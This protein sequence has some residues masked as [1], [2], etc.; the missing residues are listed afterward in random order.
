MLMPDGD[1]KNIAL[2]PIE[3]LNVDERPALA[4]EDGINTGA[5]MTMRSCFFPRGQELHSAIQGRQS[6]TAGFAVLVINNDS[7]ERIRL[8]Y[9]SQG[10]QR[11]IGVAPLVMD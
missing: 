7:V 10:F 9:F 1:H 3:R 11:R 5:R 8:A 4:L 6:W 2:F